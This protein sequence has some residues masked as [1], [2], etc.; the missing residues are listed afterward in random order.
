MRLGT[1]RDALA[2]ERAETARRSERSAPRIVG[3]A[4]SPA[5][6]T[7]ALAFLQC[8]HSTCASQ[9]TAK[10]E[11]AG[12]PSAAV[13]AA[14]PFEIAELVYDDG[15]ENQWQDWGWAPR[16]VPRDGPAKVRF[17]DYGGWILAKPGLSG[18]YDAVR[19]RVKRPAGEG[20]F[21]EVGVELGGTKRPHIH[22]TAGDAKDLGDGWTEVVLPMDRLNPVLPPSTTSCSR[23]IDRAR[24]LGN[25]R[26]I[27]LMRHV[28]SLQ[29]LTPTRSEAGGARRVRCASHSGETPRSMEP[30]G[31]STR[32]SIVWAGTN[33]DVQLGS[34]RWNVGKDCFVRSGP[35]PSLSCD[36]RHGV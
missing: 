7:M 23:R 27:A 3:R 14:G 20:E 15:L 26:S 32:R 17:S 30:R 34:Q 22:V 36:F 8:T 6:A 10:H 12:A 13:R 25:A 31:T 16:E 1:K 9:P 28:S 33:H 2:G 5:V 11:A 21:L 18:S 24:G 29:R 35:P 19:F 4:I